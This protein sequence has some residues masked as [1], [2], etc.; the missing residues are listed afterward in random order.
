V[1]SAF[2]APL[3]GGPAVLIRETARRASLDWPAMVLFSAAFGLLQAGV[4]DQSLFSTEFR[5]IE[6]WEELLRGTFV[7][8]LGLSAYL[9]QTFVVG[10][11][12]YS[13][14]APIA[15]VEALRPRHAH[16]PWLGRRG[17]AVVVLLYL[18]VAAVIHRGQLAN[19]PSHA[20]AG[21]VAGALLVAAVFVAGGVALGRRDPASVAR[22]RPGCGWWRR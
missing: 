8:P 6:D 9:A 10:H 14:C 7:E 21:Q 1:G 22:V 13:Y 3:Y 16:E 18:A 5:E 4:I 2:F 12:L 19:E 11:V 17:L 15:I 20:S